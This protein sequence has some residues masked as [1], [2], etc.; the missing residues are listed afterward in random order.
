MPYRCLCLVHPIMW[1]PCFVDAGP[2]A[3]QTWAD[4]GVGLRELLNG[5]SSARGKKVETLH[6]P[7]A[8]DFPPQPRTLFVCV[9][10]EVK[11]TYEEE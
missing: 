3:K 8:A 4:I 7:L 1:N 5:R 10:N 2:A 6:S 9:S 11:L